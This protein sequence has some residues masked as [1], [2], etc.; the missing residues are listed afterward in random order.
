MVTQPLPPPPPPIAFDEEDESIHRK[1]M[2]LVFAALI[3]LVLAILIALWLT[4]VYG[5]G[6]G[7]GGN[8]SDR[9]GTSGQ[10][11]S[12]KGA[13]SQ[14]DK[15]LSDDRASGIADDTE[16]PSVSAPEPST[17]G[18]PEPTTEIDPTTEVAL[19]VFDDRTEQIKPASLVRGSGTSQGSKVS[20]LD[21]KGNN[22][23]L[24]DGKPFK[25]A[26]YVFDISGSMYV[27]NRL[28]RVVA[29]LEEAI[30]RLKP[31]QE[32]KLIAF[33]SFAVPDDVAPGLYPAS[34]GNKQRALYWLNQPKFAG[35]TDP[36][37]AVLEAIKLKPDVIFLLTDGEFDP[38]CV[39][40]VTN[41]NQAQKAPSIINCIGLSEDI[42]NLRE[43][44]RRNNG[45]Y[46]QGK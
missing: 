22:P 6:A 28:Q 29:C 45:S 34:D 20:N 43:I 5:M 1:R 31:H 8:A 40:A 3:G 18:T 14:S 12:S 46:W 44:A 25:T 24:G 16:R 30:K 36:T 19:L 11:D 42:P 9:L 33:H 39:D 35:G 4:R 7:V 10:G 37:P 41:A 38:Y 23:F 26:V 15:P 27:D 21:A 13:K 2:I 17:P 32:F